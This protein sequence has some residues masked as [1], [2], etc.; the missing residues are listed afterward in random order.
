MVSPK[1]T[2][3]LANCAWCTHVYS[4]FRETYRGE[5]SIN[6]FIQ[7]TLLLVACIPLYNT[8]KNNQ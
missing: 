6:N 4:I 2:N 5:T 1:L 8:L 7:N 3:F